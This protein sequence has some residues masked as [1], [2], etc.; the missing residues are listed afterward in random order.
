MAPGYTATDRQPE[1]AAD[2][3]G[4]LASERVSLNS[5]R[6]FLSVAARTKSADR[7]YASH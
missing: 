7:F 6:Q 5:D 2:A 1:E 3:I 4:W